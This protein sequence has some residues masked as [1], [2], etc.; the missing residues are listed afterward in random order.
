M[1]FKFFQLDA[2]YAIRNA[3]MSAV[4]VCQQYFG[5]DCE[6]KNGYTEKH[7][8]SVRIPKRIR[9][10][11]PVNKLPPDNFPKLKVLQITDIHYDPYYQ[12]GSESDCGFPMCCRASTGMAKSSKTA[13]GKWGDY[14]KCDSPL[15][16]IENAFQHILNTHRVKHIFY[17][18]MT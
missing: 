13:A 5:E 17:Y 11:N 16:L 18:L 8:W 12:E 10:L 15:R 14:R 6:Y 3:N 4:Q 1:P 2:I 7:D 9:P